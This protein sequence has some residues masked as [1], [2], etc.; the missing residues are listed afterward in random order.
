[1][2]GVEYYPFMRTLNYVQPRGYFYGFWN[3]NKKIKS[4]TEKYYEYIRNGFSLFEYGIVHAGGKKVA[5]ELHPTDISL[6]MEKFFEFACNVQDLVTYFGVFD[7]ISKD[8]PKEWMRLF[9]QQ[10]KDM[11]LRMMPTV[12]SIRDLEDGWIIANF[13]I[14]GIPYDVPQA[15]LVQIYGVCKDLG[16]KV[17]LFSRIR[18]DLMRNLSPY[19]VSTY[20]WMGGR[21]YGNTYAFNNAKLKIYALAHKDKI[22]RSLFQVCEKY[23]LDFELILQDKKGIVPVKVSREVDKLNAVAFIEYENHLQ[24]RPGYWYGRK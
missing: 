8:F 14:V 18:F 21:R 11:G 9:L 13:G 5:E 2:G 23:H 15:H 12:R 1:M 24:K 3:A 10:G 4:R 20:N 19:S 6:Y 17:H 22:R 16:I 7:E